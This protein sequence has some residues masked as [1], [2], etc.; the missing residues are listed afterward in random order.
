MLGHLGELSSAERL[1]EAIDA[2]VASREHQTADLGGKATT[3]EF[4]DA[5]IAALKS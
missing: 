2:V 4:T 1:G 3:A 5:V